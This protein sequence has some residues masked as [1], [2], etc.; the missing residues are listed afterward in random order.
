MFRGAFGTKILFLPKVDTFVVAKL[1]M[2]HIP[3]VT[4]D[5][6]DMLRRHIFLLCLY[7]TE[8]ALFAVTF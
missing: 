3:M 7:K 6:A 8:L 5:L 4:N 1:L 2:R